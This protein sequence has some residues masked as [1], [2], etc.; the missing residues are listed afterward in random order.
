M[1]TFTESEL[2]SRALVLA[3]IAPTDEQAARA[4]RLAE[5]IATRLDANEVEAAKRDAVA[6]AR[7]IRG[8]P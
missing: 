6:I 3:L 4:T 5:E 2:L 7:S 8:K 1:N